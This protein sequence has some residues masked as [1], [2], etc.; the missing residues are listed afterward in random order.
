M[1][2]SGALGRWIERE[3][4]LV[5]PIQVSSRGGLRGLFVTEAVKAGTPLLAVPRHCTLHSDAVADDDASSLRPHERLMLALLRARAAAARAP[6]DGLSLYVASIPTE[7]PLLRDWPDGALDALARQSTAASA[8]AEAARAQRGAAARSCARVVAHAP[9]ADIVD[10]RWAEAAVRSRALDTSAA[11]GPRTL[12]LVPIFDMC[13]HRPADADARVV[14]ITSDGVAVLTAPEA[15]RAGD[16]VRFAYDAAG[17]NHQ[18]LLDYGFGVARDGTAATAGAP[19]DPA[20][21]AAVLDA[22]LSEG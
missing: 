10:L 16:E 20:A 7:I 8:L 2:A 15:L 18:L 14:E 3:G 21:V 11:G 5:G 9:F 19:H 6:D 13:N 17:G 12:Q 22:E 1:V 4:G